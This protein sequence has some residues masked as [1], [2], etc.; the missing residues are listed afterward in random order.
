MN[1][2]QKAA[3]WRAGASLAGFLKMMFEST[4]ASF[5]EDEKELAYR[6][7]PAFAPAKKSP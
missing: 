1:W 6:K 2:F 7:I 5:G 3:G 4:L